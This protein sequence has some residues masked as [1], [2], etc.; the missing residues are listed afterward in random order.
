[1]A[2]TARVLVDTIERYTPRFEYAAFVFRNFTPNPLPEKPGVL[3]KKAK[4]IADSARRLLKHLGVEDAKEAVDG[5]GIAWIQQLLRL[6]EGAD[7]DALVSATERIGRLSEIFDA[8]RAAG[9]LTG[10]ADTA[11]A[12]AVEYGDLFGI[13]G[14]SGDRAFNNWLAEMMSI[15]KEV[16]GKPP[17]FN[18]GATGGAREG[19]AYGRFVSFVQAAY[20]PIVRG[21]AAAGEPLGAPG[22]DAIRSRAREIARGT[23]AGR[24]RI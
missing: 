1:M 4:Q 2:A 5:P 11:A 13:G 14:H 6:A 17:R 3:A 16:T 7:E 18:V 15:W 20:A 21:A 23:A 10:W 24:K 8:I 12:D 22:A 19:K 9:E